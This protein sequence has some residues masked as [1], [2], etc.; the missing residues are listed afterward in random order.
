MK[1]E[2]QERLAANLKR[3]RTS[4][5]ISQAQLAEKLEIDRSLYALYESGRRI[6]DPELLYEI[7]R[8]FGIRM[9]ILLDADPEN[10]AAEASCS[11]VC[12]N[13]D[14]HILSIYRHLSPFS[15]GI[16]IS[17]MHFA[18][19]AKNKRK[20]RQMKSADNTCR[21]FRFCSDRNRFAHLVQFI[22]Q[23]RGK[24]LI[25]EKDQFISRLQ[26]G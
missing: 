25:A 8:L 7:A 22:L 18:R 15:K 6:P 9:E 23:L 10:V 11:K 21:L 4:K 2:T 14:L 13:S 26:Y 1:F 19:P 12:D 5:G 24:S 16:L 3:L 17:R 20:R